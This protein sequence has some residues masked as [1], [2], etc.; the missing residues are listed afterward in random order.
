VRVRVRVR[1]RL[2]LRLRPRP[3]PRLRVSRRHHVGEGVDDLHRVVAQVH[4]LV[5]RHVVVRRQLRP[6]DGG[7][8]SRTKLHS[9]AT[10]A[11]AATAASAAVIAAAAAAA[12]GH[13]RCCYY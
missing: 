1:V 5:E 10:A 12:R 8:A 6:A 13:R 4:Q 2:R 11:A 7:H 3:R 9:I